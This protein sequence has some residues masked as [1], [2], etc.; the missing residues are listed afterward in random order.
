MRTSKGREL[1]RHG[2][3]LPCCARQRRRTR[4]YV[5]TSAKDSPS[6][7]L[8]GTPALE[9]DH[10]MELA[11]LLEEIPE[12]LRRELLLVLSVSDE[13]RA[14]IIGDL[15]A[16]GRTTLADTLMDL[17]DDDILRLQLARLLRDAGSTF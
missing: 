3:D 15:W 10:E 4:R 13:E 7:A 17:Q 8:D 1:S 12:G 16:R 6:V 2:N 14:R 11:R 5:L 9:S